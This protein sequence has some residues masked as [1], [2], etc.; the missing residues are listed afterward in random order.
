MKSMGQIAVQPNH[1]NFVGS[2]QIISRLSG[3]EKEEAKD[4]KVEVKLRRYDPEEDE[5]SHR[6]SD[7]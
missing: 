1:K 6:R 7:A 5:E 3:L 2:A 4:V